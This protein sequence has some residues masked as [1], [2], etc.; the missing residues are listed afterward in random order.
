MVTI[1]DFK[2]VNKDNGETFYVLIVEGTPEAVRSTLSGK[3]YFTA[4]RARI[5]TTLDEK[6]CKALIGTELE[7]TIE[8]IPC[9][10]YQYVSEQTGEIFKLSY[11]WEYVDLSLMEIQERP[12]L[13]KVSAG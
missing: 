1:K 13:K 10:S 8:K 2:K 4:H 5:P 9:E 6:A 12:A 3:P 7:G 11:R